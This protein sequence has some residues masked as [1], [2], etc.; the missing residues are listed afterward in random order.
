MIMER[1][2]EYEDISKFHPF[3][4]N[5]HTLHPAEM[6]MPEMLPSDL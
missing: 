5:D 3:P 4:V 6:P 2:G 1:K